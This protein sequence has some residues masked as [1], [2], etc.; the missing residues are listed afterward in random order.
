MYCGFTI[1]RDIIDGKFRIYFNTFLPNID[2]KIPY[3]INQFELAL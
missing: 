2:T 1:Q 3:F